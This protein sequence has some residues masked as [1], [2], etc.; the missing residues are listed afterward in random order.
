VEVLLRVRANNTPDHSKSLCET[1]DNSTI[2]KGHAVSERIVYCAIFRKTLTHD[3]SE[4][5]GYEEKQALTLHQ[6]NTMA[7]LLECKEGK[8]GFR[9]LTRSEIYG[10]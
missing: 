5:S 10:D 9:K 6:M 1:C 3:I 2:A 7:V 4:C 8:Y